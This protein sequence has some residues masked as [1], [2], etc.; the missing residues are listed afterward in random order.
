MRIDNF[1]YGFTF[2]AEDEREWE[3]LKALFLPR[4]GD[5]DSVFIVEVDEEAKKVSVEM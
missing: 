1:F 5:T 3:Q 4:V 2:L